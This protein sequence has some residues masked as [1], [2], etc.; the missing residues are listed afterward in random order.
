MLPSKLQPNSGFLPKVL[1]ASIGELKF[2]L[3]ETC[4]EKVYELYA[5]VLYAY[6]KND[7]DQLKSVIDLLVCVRHVEGDGR[8]QDFKC[9]HCL[10][11]KIS[12]LRLQIRNK[13]VDFSFL[14]NL[15]MEA[16]NFEETVWRAEAF[17]VMALAYGQLNNYEAASCYYHKAASL[18]NESGL[19][20]KS[21][22]SFFN[23]IVAESRRFP[24]ARL[25]IE[26]QQVAKLAKDAG[27]FDVAGLALLNISREYQKIKSLLLALQL[28]EQAIHCF[29]AN[30]G[31]LHFDQAILHKCHILIDLERFGEA[32]MEYERAKMSSFAE[33]QEGLVVIDAIL[34]NKPLGGS[35]YFQNLTP[36]WR[37]RLSHLMQGDSVRKESAEPLSDLES[38]LVR[39]VAE[40]ARDKFELIYL[41]YGDT[42]EFSLLEDRFKDLLK[43]VRK[44]R[45]ELIIYENK[46]YR[47]SDLGCLKTNIVFSKSH[48]HLLKSRKL[49]SLAA[50]FLVF[51][52]VVKSNRANARGGA[53]VEI[54][55]IDSETGIE[56]KYKEILSSGESAKFGPSYIETHENLNAFRP[57]LVK[58]S[59]TYLDLKTKQNVRFDGSGFL[60]SFFIRLFVLTAS[61]VSQGKNTEI[62]HFSIQ[63]EK[64]KILG[65]LTSNL[66]DVEIIEVENP[67]LLSLSS[68]LSQMVFSLAEYSSS[69]RQFVL[70][71]NAQL[72][73]KQKKRGAAWVPGEHQMLASEAVIP[74]PTWIQPSEEVLHSA[75][76]QNP[77]R[78]VQELGNLIVYTRIA[79]GTSG[80]PMVTSASSF[81]GEN[82]WVVSGIALRVSRFFNYSVFASD[83]VLSKILMKYV[84]GKRGQLDEFRWNVK[85]GVTFRQSLNKRTQEITP[86]HMSVALLNEVPT[87]NGVEADGGNGASA[88]SF[89]PATQ[90]QPGMLLDSKV[91]VGFWLDPFATGKTLPFYADL[92][93]Y[94]Y[95][96]KNSSYVYSVIPLNSDLISVL[97][98]RLNVSALKEFSL[99]GNYG[100]YIAVSESQISVRINNS[101]C[102]VSF[103][104]DKEGRYSLSSVFQPV[105]AVRNEN[106]SE[107]CLVDFRDFFMINLQLFERVDK[108]VAPSM[109]YKKIITTGLSQREHDIREIFSISN[110]KTDYLYRDQ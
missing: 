27:E 32:R 43:R 75:D 95:L 110:I 39:H 44:K 54:K 51:C 67:K 47:L 94:S 62:T 77:M 70:T 106:D 83:A 56:Q 19:K 10:V 7:Q 9:A 73:W 101:V 17:F 11:Q 78:S 25:I 69:Q 22:K 6:L 12:I 3:S 74:L 52:L 24:E 5:R 1:E 68:N 76:F 82:N 23:H 14:K 71:Q 64:L 98:G 90:F 4:G 8:A 79:H 15:E 40:K 105:V 34:E 86:L 29:A 88:T 109:T 36:T 50:V 48:I 16:E 103:I 42:A 30:V 80:G 26:Y 28:C 96:I 107:S 66:D 92:G 84:S 63:N 2:L 55:S 89:L 99:K 102:D 45:P 49:A 13:S 18:F 93:S 87:G 20:K 97:A 91:V 46:L 104:L 81:M 100:S 33:I 108:I 72:F 41:L 58:V 60:V 35:V 38:Q 57:W 53:L 37:E 31:T 61:H 85:D 59:S 21:V 65:R